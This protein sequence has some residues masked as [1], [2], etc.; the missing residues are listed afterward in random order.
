MAGEREAARRVRRALQEELGSSEMRTGRPEGGQ[1][2][3]SWRGPWWSGPCG[4]SG[5]GDPGA[6][7]D[8]AVLENQREVSEW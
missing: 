7:E 6:Q 4:G 3:G 2:G 1:R 5:R 8:T